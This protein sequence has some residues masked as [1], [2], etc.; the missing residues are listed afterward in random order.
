M[1]VV[2]VL[3]VLAPQWRQC[4]VR[5]AVC[6]PSL[7]RPPRQHPRPLVPPVRSPSR[8][9][10]CWRRSIS[11]GTRIVS[12]VPVATVVWAR[13]ARRSSPRLISFSVNVTTW[14]KCVSSLAQCSSDTKITNKH[15]RPKNR[16]FG[17]TGMCSACNKTIPAF[18]MAMKLNGGRVYHRKWRAVALFTIEVCSAETNYSLV[19]FYQNLV[20][21]F[22]CSQCNHRFCVGD[23]FHLHENRILCEYDFEEMTVY[24]AN[25]NNNSSAATYSNHIEKLKKQTESL[26]SSLSPPPVVN[27]ND[28]GSS[29]Y[30]SPDS[31][32]LSDSKWQEAKC[33]YRH[34]MII[35][36]TLLSSSH[37]QHLSS[38]SNLC[39]H[40]S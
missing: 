16:L 28:D 32:S 39:N 13:W 23:R 12:N 22:Q 29:G 1:P 2:R 33:H 25:N 3:A 26:A 36:I 40:S 9:G 15:C 8:S 19:C 38:Q 24:G 34:W 17:T 6:S 5:R 14:G 7:L 30:G 27:V 20:E 4:P 11:C 35:I 31:M 37:S 10:T 18:E 21:C